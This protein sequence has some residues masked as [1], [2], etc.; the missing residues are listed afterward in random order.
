M[1][2]TARSS[3][4][5]ITTSLL[6]IVILN[7]Q[8]TTQARKSKCSAE[9][10]RQMDTCA[11][12]MGFLGDHSF[13]VPKDLNGMGKFCAELKDSIGCIQSYSREC[14]QGFTRQLLSGL[15]RRGKQQYN[16]ICDSN[17]TKRQFM[18]RMSCLTDDKIQTF[19]STMDASIARFE[20]ISSKVKSDLRLPAL[21]CSFQIFSRDTE[22]TLDKLCGKPVDRKTST[23]EF[24]QKIVGGTTGEFLG[25]ICENLRSIDECKV[26]VKTSQSMMELEDVT[27][28]VASGKLRPKNKSLI[29][30]LIEV[31]D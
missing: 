19:H 15:L 8:S 22:T 11:A 9:R 5:L 28:S 24:V 27:S 14:L 2:L 30:V 13:V 26:S 29:P 21:C 4:R 7:N 31:L 16:S 10:D 25:L 12:K 3:T 17:N 1:K 23:Q 6:I 20:F 18:K